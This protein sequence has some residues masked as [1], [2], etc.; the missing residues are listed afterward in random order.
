VVSSYLG[1]VAYEVMATPMT[2]AIV[3]FLKR[4]EGLDTFDLATDFN[5]FHAG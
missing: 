5:P 1:K 2:Y 4:K 3:N